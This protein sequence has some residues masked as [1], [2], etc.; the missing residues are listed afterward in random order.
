MAGNQDEYTLSLKVNSSDFQ[1]NIQESIKSV[2]LLSAELDKASQKTTKSINEI[3][4]AQKKLGS[5]SKSIKISSPSVSPSSSNAKPISE[6]N[7]VAKE[8][9]ATIA[10]LE[11]EVNRLTTTMNKMGQST[12]KTVTPMQQSKKEVQDLARQKKEMKAFVSDLSNTR[13]ALYDLGATMTTVSATFAALPTM[14]T[15]FSLSYERSFKSVER[16]SGLTGESVN[17]LKNELINLTTEMPTSFGDITNIATIGAQL[18]VASDKLSAFTEVVGKFSATTNVSVEKSAIGLGRLAQLTKT[19]GDE[20]EN[21]GSSIYQ[22]GVTSIATEGEILEVASQIATAGDLAGF[23]NEQIIALSGSLA[24]L[25]IQPESARG[26]MMRIFNTISVAASDGGEALEQIASISGSSA[27]QIQNDWG[28]NSQMVFT[29]FLEGLNG[30]SEA[31]GNTNTI[32]KDLGIS[33]VRDIRALEVLANNM[34]VYTQAQRE[35]NEA[36]LSGTAL[37]DGYAI[38]VDN[39]LDK[40]TM[41]FNEFKALAVAVGNSVSFLS[42]VIDVVSS[43]VSWLR[44]LTEGNGVVKWIVGFGLAIMASVAAFT[45]YQ[46]ALAFA[47]ASVAGMITSINGLANAGTTLEGG[48]IKL[49]KQ[50]LNMS[51]ILNKATRDVDVAK[52]KLLELKAAQDGL[53]ASSARTMTFGT[54]IRGVGDVAKKSASVL[55]NVA[56]SLVSTVGSFAKAGLWAAGISA[57]LYLIPK[58]YSHFFKD[59]GAEAE[60]FFGDMDNYTATLRKDTEEFRKSGERVGLFSVEIEKTGGAVDE[61]A[62]AI[63]RMTGYQEVFGETVETTTDKVIDQTVAIGENTVAAMKKALSESDDFYEHW[64]KNGDELER[65]GFNLNMFVDS[66]ATGNYDTFLDNLN[67]ERI[68]KDSQV[69]I[70]QI[71][72]I[73]EKIK[74]GGYDTTYDIKAVESL[75]EQLVLLESSTVKSIEHLRNIAKGQ[76]ENFQEAAQKS[77]FLNMVIGTTNGVL[78]DTEGEIDDV[79]EA[80]SKFSE[81]IVALEASANSSLGSFYDKVLEGGFTFNTMSDAGINNIS[82]LSSAIDSMEKSAGDDL[83]SFVSNLTGMVGMFQQEFG[84]LP[85]ELDYLYDTL[86]RLA[87]E[88]WDVK[89]DTVNARKQVY[90]LYNDMLQALRVLREATD[91]YNPD[92]T[93]SSSRARAAALNDIERRR[94]EILDARNKHTSEMNRQEDLYAKAQH[95]AT[96]AARKDTKAKKDNTKENKKNAETVRTLSD[97]V[98]DLS[99]VLSS[100]VDFEFSFQIATD[101]RMTIIDDIRQEAIDAE[102][103]LRDLR[104]QLREL[105]ADLQVKNSDKTILERQIEISRQFGDVLSYE[106][107]L[108]SLAELEAEMNANR[109]EQSDVMSQIGVEL[110]NLDKG[111]N[112]N[113]A[114]ARKNRDDILKLV[115]SYQQQIEAYAKTGASQAQISRYT[116]SLSKDFERQAVSLGYSRSE[117]ARYVSTFDQFKKV[118]DSIPRDLTVKVN[119]NTSSADKALLE[120]ASKKRTTT[121]DVKANTSG[122]DSA[123]TSNKKLANIIGVQAELKALLAE[124]ERLSRPGLYDKI[125]PLL[126][127]LKQ[128]QNQVKGFKDGGFTG[129][130]PFNAIAGVV[131]GGEHVVP[132]RHVNQR[133]GLPNADYLAHAVRGYRGGGFVTPSGGTMVFPETIMVEIAPSSIRA[134]SKTNAP[135]T[136]MLDGKVVANSVNRQNIDSSFRGTQ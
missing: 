90:S 82:A 119:A 25:G 136:L 68:R 122:V 52:Q 35:S 24:S 14:V 66:I 32:L 7:A 39:V 36:Y 134:L 117:I 21:L 98:S 109:I 120:F 57:A 106:K 51:R 8:Y 13:Y 94:N 132:A 50:F 89:V 92:E 19:A 63:S 79:T 58:A 73:Q 101:N 18:D 83:G 71:E 3:V 91:Y 9:S 28:T 2:Q 78:N 64:K 40:I 133:T 108:A 49:G 124:I 38:Q 100:V 6:A 10:R 29:R 27:Q 20:Y 121:V 48:F 111:L 81:S 88:Q 99:S 110:G 62:E 93:P 55:K 47:R 33:A 30:I 107:G 72:K 70:E 97:Y 46:A 15:A 127:K 102:K 76:T 84:E 85:P 45:A 80:V 11:Q 65:A 74:N 34:D 23:T 77:E 86:A 115:Q 69:I 44:K 128:L 114:S 54:V 123:I 1:K 105:M 26:S 17:Q 131:H 126:P 104:Q 12:Q 59:W 53:S 5:G 75:K 61:T 37:S 129:H 125:P 67:A 16:T 31:G 95:K 87:G 43:V 60:K 42:P 135:V 118:V 103:R 96:E 22:V 130:I 41:L 112:G 116:Q 113:S 56:S 4:N